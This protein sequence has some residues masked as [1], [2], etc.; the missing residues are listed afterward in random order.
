MYYVFQIIQ[1]HEFSLLLIIPDKIFND[2]KKKSFR[3]LLGHI[4]TE[5]WLFFVVVVVFVFTQKRIHI[6]WKCA[7]NLLIWGPCHS[8]DNRTHS[9]SSVFIYEVP[10]PSVCLSGPLLLQSSTHNLWKIGETVNFSPSSH[11]SLLKLQ[12]TFHNIALQ[13]V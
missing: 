5:S 7:C 11:N 1:L 13:F 2:L 10:F 9:A 8:P 6:L 4:T 3:N 12:I